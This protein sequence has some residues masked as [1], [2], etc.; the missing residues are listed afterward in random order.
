MYLKTIAF[1]GLVSIRP[2]GSIS[3]VFFKEVL[4]KYALVA[5]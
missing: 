5:L 4:H 3:G 2:V 1:D